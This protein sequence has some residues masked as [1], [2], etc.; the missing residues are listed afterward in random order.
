MEYKVEI[1]DIF[2][3]THDVKRIT[4]KKPEGYSFEPGQ[5]TEVAINLPG[6]TDK[7]RPFTFTSLPDDN[8]LEFIIKSYRDHNG[9]TNEIGSLVTG[10]SLIIG[11]SWGAISYKGKGTFIAG[12]AGVTPFISI[13]RE[14]ASKNELTGNKLLFANKTGKDVILESAF[15]DMLR[16]NFISVLSRENI[17]GHEYG[18]IDMEFLKIHLEGYSQQFY[19]CGPDKMVKN[20]SELLQ[21]MGANTDALVFEK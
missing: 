17:E 18:H 1:T 19:I 12:G 8:H 6:Y 2:S 15:Q 9:V 10:N 7:K 13:F 3:L 21:K 4:T 20:I 5:A 14:L 16:D 11:D